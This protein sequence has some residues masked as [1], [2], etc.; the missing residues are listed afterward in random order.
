MTIINKVLMGGWLCVLNL[1]PSQATEQEAL[2]QHTI[3]IG[4]FRNILSSC[5]PFCNDLANE[6]NDPEQ[7][8]TLEGRPFNQPFYGTD[9]QR[10][11][12]ESDSH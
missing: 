8:L 5:L 6:E 1:C 3:G 11:Y 10:H 9:R 12:A 4:Y 2:P 7:Y